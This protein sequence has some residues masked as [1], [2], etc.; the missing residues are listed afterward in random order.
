MIDNSG[1]FGRD[2]K[3]YVVFADFG[4]RGPGHVQVAVGDGQVVRVPATGDMGADGEIVGGASVYELKRRNVSA[5]QAARQ[6]DIDRL[7][8]LLEALDR[9]RTRDRADLAEALVDQGVMFG[10]DC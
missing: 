10:P 6:L 5:L 2:S 9:D 7:A 4:G 1:G 8:A 3:R